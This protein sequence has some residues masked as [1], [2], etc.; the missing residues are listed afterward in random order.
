MMTKKWFFYVLKCADETLYT[1]ITCDVTKRLETH[2]SGR[3]AKYT[4][5]RLPC[6]LLAFQEVGNKSTALKAEYAFKQLRRQEKL[7]HVSAG[8]QV[9]LDRFLFPEDLDAQKKN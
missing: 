1:G 7:R 6:E 9:F 3:G 5:S 4:R 2:N 8:I